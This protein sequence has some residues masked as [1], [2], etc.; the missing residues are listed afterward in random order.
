MAYTGSFVPDG[1]N[2]SLSHGNFQQSDLSKQMQSAMHNVA[3]R[4]EAPFGLKV[5]GDFM[6]YTAENDQLMQVDWTDGR[7]SSSYTLTGGQRIS[8]YS[9]YAD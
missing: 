7:T 3:L 8:S 5:G 4:Y 2:L 6:R 9:L 1:D